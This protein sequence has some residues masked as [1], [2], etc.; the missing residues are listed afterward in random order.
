MAGAAVVPRLVA[1]GLTM[2]PDCTAAVVTPSFR[3][4]PGLILAFEGR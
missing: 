3:S 4:R 1:S 2:A